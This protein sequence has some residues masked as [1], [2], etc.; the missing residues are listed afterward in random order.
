MS[1]H[2]GDYKVAKEAFVADNAGDTLWRINSVCLTALV[3]LRCG[4]TAGAG[5]QALRAPLDPHTQSTYQLWQNALP[6]LSTR[7]R[8]GWLLVCAEYILLVLPLLCTLTIFSDHPLWFNLA[9]YMGVGFCQLVKRSRASP[10][11]QEA[12]QARHSRADG[13][14]GGPGREE[15][16]EQASRHGPTVA[17]IAHRPFVTVWR[18]HM[19]LMTIICIL[20]VDFP[21]FPRSFG[22]CETWGTSLVSEAHHQPTSIDAC[23]SETDHQKIPTSDGS[24][25]WVLCL[26]PRARVSFAFLAKAVFAALHHKPTGSSAEKRCR[27]CAWYDPHHI[28]QGYRV[29]S[30]SAKSDL[31]RGVPSLTTLIAA[32]RSTYRSTVCTGT[33]SS[34][35]DYFHCVEQ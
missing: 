22:K 13:T 10:S 17:V 12:L 30:E 7:L 19:M 28:G 25:R 20:A 24:G 32:S 35:W 2:D 1:L 18:A 27:P 31:C 8:R 26:F 29:P 16:K 6:L 15:E 14:E 11:F 5:R 9:M 23:W 34:R 33:S 21:V 4:A 3:R